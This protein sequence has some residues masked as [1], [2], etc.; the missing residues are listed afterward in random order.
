M[1][2]IDGPG[3]FR[4]MT[5][6][7]PDLQT[8]WQTLFARAPSTRSLARPPAVQGTTSCPLLASRQFVSDLAKLA[9]QLCMDDMTQETWACLDEQID[10]VTAAATV[11]ALRL[12][13]RCREK[14]AFFAPDK[15]G[16]VKQLPASRASDC[17]VRRTRASWGVELFQ[18]YRMRVLEW[19]DTGVGQ[20]KQ[21]AVLLMRQGC[22]GG[23]PV[24]LV[25]WRGS[26]SLTDYGITDA[27]PKQ[28]PLPFWPSLGRG[29]DGAEDDGTSTGSNGVGGATSAAAPSAEASAA[30]SAAASASSDGS[31]RDDDDA[32]SQRASSSLRARWMPLMGGNPRPCVTVGLW[33]AYAGSASRDLLGEGPRARV[34]AAVEEA[35]R[36]EP[37]CRVVVT[38]HSL[39]GSLATLCALDLLAASRLTPSPP[40]RQDQQ[41]QQQPSDGEP[42]FGVVPNGR[43]GQAEGGEPFFGVVPNGRNGRA[44]GGEPLRSILGT[45]PSVT[46]VGDDSERNGQA[47]GG[48]PSGPLRVL[49]DAGLTLCTFASPRLFNAAFQDAASEEARQGR[50]RALR[51]V[52]RGDVITRLPP[53]VLGGSHG[54]RP[55]LVLHPKAEEPKTER[56]AVV[57]QVAEAAAV[58]DQVA[59]AAFEAAA[60]SA[61]EGS[62]ESEPPARAS[63]PI[64][65]HDDGRDDYDEFE[66]PPRLDMHA[67][68]SHALF[69]SGENTETRKLTIPIGEEWPLRLDSGADDADQ[70]DQEDKRGTRPVLTW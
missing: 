11:D 48:G 35:L 9:E 18:R 26:K 42:F 34:R 65:F 54:V 43:N 8:N 60:G 69:L 47:E 53:R 29:C 31:S 32:A 62:N 38:G 52:V 30:A 45:T 15:C 10:E 23:R 55:R 12:R 25:V 58:A 50:L 24:L 64:T 39:G 49:A 20:E 3:L 59:E 56:A 13:I 17:A 6:S 1:M 57:D 2:P 44:E 67:H 68:T 41:P 66:R 5:S 61:A 21:A 51:V 63:P 4:R 22:P 33:N 28:M 19:V 7:L 37:R 16:D 40:E 46:A 36:E 70:L 14:A 27:S